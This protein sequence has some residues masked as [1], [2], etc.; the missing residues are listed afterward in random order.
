V[1]RETNY[2]GKGVDQLR[3]VIESIR[4]NPTDRRIL[5]SSWNPVD[6]PKMALPPCHVL[7]Q[8][9][10]DTASASEKPTLSC[11]L[12]QRS[13]DLGLGVPFNIA[14][15]ALL[16]HLVAQVTDTRPA[17]LVHVLGDTHVYRTHIDPLRQQL[18]NT[19]RPLP[20]LRLN[21][22]VRDIVRFRAED[23]ELIGYDPYPALKMEM[24]V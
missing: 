3:N 4:R 15:Y 14:S 18:Q 9:V 19:P 23:I 11:L 24:A 5:M 8:F 2:E 17:E 13:A 10:V 6:L 20:Q 1:N 22:A 12:Y 16:L 21:P 7:C